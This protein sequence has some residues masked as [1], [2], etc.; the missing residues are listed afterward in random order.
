MELTK[1]FLTK[2]IKAIKNSDK[3]VFTCD[4]LSKKTGV[5]SEVIRGLLIKYNPLINFE[6]NFDLH[7]I[8][9]DMEK[10][11][12]ISTIKKK[13]ARAIRKDELDEYPSTLFYIYKKMTVPGGILDLGYKLKKDDIRIIRKLLK[14]DYA[15]ISQKK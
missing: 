11:L 14:R 5:R 4:D 12:S 10:D 7:E 6:Y 9:P 13:R 8:L 1:T 2:S 15:K 3:K